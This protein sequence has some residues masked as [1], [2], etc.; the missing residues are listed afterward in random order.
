MPTMAINNC[1]FSPTLKIPEVPITIG[2]QAQLLIAETLC[3]SG[4]K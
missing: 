1:L 3:A 4:K 2:R